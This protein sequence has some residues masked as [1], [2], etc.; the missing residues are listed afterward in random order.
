MNSTSA[1]KWNYPCIRAL[2]LIIRYLRKI[3][4]VVSVYYPCR[5]RVLDYSNLAA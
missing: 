5:I 1:K 4:R 3:I 2:T